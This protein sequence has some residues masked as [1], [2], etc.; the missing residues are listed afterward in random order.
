M[1]D[2]ELGSLL[3]GVLFVVLQSRGLPEAWRLTLA[4]GLLGAFTTFSTFSLDTL[5]LIEQGAVGRAVL[6]TLASVALCLGAAAVGIAVTR[7]AI[8]G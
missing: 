3:M 7:S 8:P 5:A 4:V 1:D 6:Y 2:L